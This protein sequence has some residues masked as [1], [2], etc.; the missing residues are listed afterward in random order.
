MSWVQSS[1]GRVSVSCRPIYPLLTLLAVESPAEKWPETFTKYPLLVKYPYLLP[2]ATASCITLLGAILSLF[3]ARDGGVRG[4]AIRLRLPEKLLGIRTRQGDDAAMEG[5][6][7][8]RPGAFVR[9]KTVFKRPSQPVAAAEPAADP[10]EEPATSDLPGA[11]KVDGAAYGYSTARPAEEGDSRQLVAEALRRRRAAQDQPQHLNFSQRLL[12]ANEAQVM[13]LTDLWVAAAK[14]VDGPA[15]PAEDEDEEPERGRL[16]NAPRPSLLPRRSSSAS[17]MPA[18][19]THTGIRAR[20]PIEGEDEILP[21]RRE[22]SADS[23]TTQATL[24]GAAGG[25]SMTQQ[26]PLFIIFQYGLL[27]LHSTTHDQ[28][29]LSYLSSSY[30]A[31]G[32]GL[33]PSGYAQLIALMSF[34]QISYQFYLYP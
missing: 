29:F 26:L 1:A 32:L 23:T 18:I 2:C 13:S 33:Q 17:A 22:P 11:S 6:A 7:V 14:H 9:L 27:A 5:G 30:N 25:Q 31:G 16:L 19:F 3:L 24:A 12:M 20:V 8:R 10:E 15:P 28:I 21:L 34:A 4:G